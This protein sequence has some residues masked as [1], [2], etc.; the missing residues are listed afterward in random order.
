M[1]YQIIF[2]K[3]FTF[4]FTWTSL[5]IFDN[6]LASDAAIHTQCFLIIKCH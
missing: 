1:Q 2:G 4:F 3:S 6:L 5:D